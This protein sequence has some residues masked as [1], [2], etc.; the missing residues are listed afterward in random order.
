M[1]TSRVDLGGGARVLVVDAEPVARNALAGAFRHGGFTTREA[2]SGGAAAHAIAEFRPDLVVLEAA[3]PDI[4]GFALARRLGERRPR[5]PMIFV[6]GRNATE[7][8]VAGLAVGDDYVTKP[9]SVVEVVARARAVLRRT[10]REDHGVLRF[11]DV[12]LS[13]SSHEVRR[14]G[15][16]VDLTPTEFNLLRY[17]MLN[18]RAVLTRRQILDNVWDDDVTVDRSVVETYVSYLRKKLDRSGPSLIRTVRGV[19]YTLREPAT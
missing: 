5:T 19:G 8:K 15:G 12:L 10:R 17:F 9:C 4:D 1:H 3:L 2:A 13:E 11:A 14:A 18:P 6:T 16:L 7:D